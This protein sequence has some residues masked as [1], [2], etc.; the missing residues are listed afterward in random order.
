MSTRRKISSSL[1]TVEPNNRKVKERLTEVQA[2]RAKSQFTVPA[3]L[4]DELATN[5]FLRW[6]SPELQNSVGV[7][8]D[9]VAVFAKTREL[10]DH[11]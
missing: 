3:K 6:E 4:E 11:F 7:G 8:T 10:K 5:P 2:L 9:A 1:S